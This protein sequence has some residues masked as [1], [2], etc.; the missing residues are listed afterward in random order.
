[1][2]LAHHR[3]GPRRH[4]SCLR[5]SLVLLSVLACVITLLM[6]WWSNEDLPALPITQVVESEESLNLRLPQHA[7]DSSRTT[8]TLREVVSRSGPPLV[9]RLM[10]PAAARHG[11][12]SSGSRN[13]TVTRQ[14]ISDDLYRLCYNRGSDTCRWVVPNTCGF[15]GNVADVLKDPAFANKTI[16]FRGDSTLRD[17][18]SEFAGDCCKG[19]QIAF[20]AA[21]YRRAIDVVKQQS[22][23]ATVEAA[24]SGFGTGFGLPFVTGE[25]GAKKKETRTGN[26]TSV[27]VVRSI[28]GADLGKADANWEHRNLIIRTGLRQ[29]SPTNEAEGGS[30]YLRTMFHFDYDFAHLAEPPV[31]T[32]QAQFGGEKS[33]GADS[34]SPSMLV[35]PGNMTSTPL[36]EQQRILDDFSSIVVGLSNHVDAAVVSLGIYEARWFAQNNFTEIEMMKYITGDPNTTRPRGVDVVDTILHGVC[37]VL[38]AKAGIFYA[39]TLEC[40]ALRK[41]KGA[42]RK[43]ASW[44]SRASFLLR[45]M[46]AYIAAELSARP[47]SCPVYAIPAF[48]CYGN[49]WVCTN[50]GMHGRK[51]SHYI[52][53]KTQL[54]RLALQK[55]L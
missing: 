31:P 33:A 51:T 34:A 27:L 47:S 55:I 7:P 11:A 40:R 29:Q 45:Q 35:L 16:V 39:P 3:G 5:L 2:H 42:S 19:R 4:W 21:T 43:G 36:K 12:A 52:R 54:L 41:S 48:L 25:S 14:C 49:H 18:F 15:D 53:S 1:M 38:G 50:D 17:M 6:A 20:D 8:P 9:Q 13:Q 46:N 37:D 30:G 23:T 32:S 26:E 28:A 22:L 44:C 10:N 24:T